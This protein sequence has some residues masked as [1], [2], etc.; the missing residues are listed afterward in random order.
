MRQCSSKPHEG[1]VAAVREIQGGRWEDL[2]SSE[3]AA[4]GVSS[5]KV[6]VK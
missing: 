3:A 2:R 6:D 5:I 1:D 4:E